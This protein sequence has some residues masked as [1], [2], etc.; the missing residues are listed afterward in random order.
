[1]VAIEL[2]VVTKRT[3]AERMVTKRMLEAFV[4]VKRP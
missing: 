1:V 4:L 3:A 2:K